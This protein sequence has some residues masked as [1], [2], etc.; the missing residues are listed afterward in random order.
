MLTYA[1][2][3]KFNK[4]HDAHTGRFT[5]RAGQRIPTLTK[6]KEPGTYTR[7][8]VQ[9]VVSVKEAIPLILAGKT[10]E[11]K[12]PGKVNSLLKK[13]HAY[14]Q[15]AAEKGDAA[16][17]FD[18]CKIA[19]KGVSFFC[20]QHLGLPRIV[21]PQL[22]GMP[23]KGTP[24]DKLPKDADGAVD[25]GP[26]FLDYLKSI[27]I[28]FKSKEVK[29]ESLMASQKELV[30]AKVAKRVAKDKYCPS[31]PVFTTRDNYIVDGHHA[32][33]GVIGRDADDKHLGDKKLRVIE[34]DAPISEILHLA[35]RWTKK[36][37]LA[38]KT[39][40]ASTTKKM[41]FVSVFQAPA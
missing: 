11:L 16:P 13:L 36:F 32:W 22:G 9:E 25:V 27:G 3:F 8:H 4:E 26:E 5:F 6:S 15:D 38:P 19:V 7:P 20:G 33:A 2:V 28:G 39:G 21:M 12:H 30:G 1:A 29:A 17:N 10:V 41:D 31:K 23:V 37:G 34:I 24:A 35:N 14:A 40:D 18:A